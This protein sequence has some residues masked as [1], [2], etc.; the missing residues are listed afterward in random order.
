M[1][2]PV[3]FAT[4]PLIR[5]S[6]GANEPKFNGEARETAC[7]AFHRMGMTS[8]AVGEGGLA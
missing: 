6:G 2:G 5:T 3:W 7:A 1:L 4:I 8:G